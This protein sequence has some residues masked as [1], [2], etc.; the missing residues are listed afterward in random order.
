MRSFKILNTREH[1]FRWSTCVCCFRGI[2]DIS[3]CLCCRTHTGAAH[4]HVLVPGLARPSC[5]YTEQFKTEPRTGEQPQSPELFCCRIRWFFLVTWIYLSFFYLS[6]L[7]TRVSDPEKYTFSESCG[8]TFNKWLHTQMVFQSDEAS[9][10][11]K[12]LCNSILRLCLQ[13]RHCYKFE[14]LVGVSLAN[15]RV[16]HTS[17]E[18]QEAAALCGTPVQ[19]T[20]WPL[21]TVCARDVPAHRLTEG[22]SRLKGG[23]LYSPACVSHL[24]SLTPVLK[25]S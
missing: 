23:R 7:V 15:C 16:L 10:N 13:V 20:L 19:W 6:F 24:L 9:C 18:C 12:S 14:S 5:C 17:P 2:A 21:G 22:V 25:F 8:L 1:T 3:R 11:C 4:R